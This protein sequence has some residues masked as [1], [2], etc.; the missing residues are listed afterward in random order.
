MRRARCLLRPVSSAKRPVYNVSSYSNRRWASSTGAI[1]TSADRVDMS[2]TL[3]SPYETFLDGRKSERVTLVTETGERAF[4]ANHVPFLGEAHPGVVEVLTREEGNDVTKR[5]FVSAGI[6]TFLPENH[7]KISC[8]EV[9]N[10]SEVDPEAV[11][12]GLSHWNSR[13]SDAK[14]ADEQFIA[15]A[16]VNLHTALADALK[17]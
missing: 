1:E 16:G 6:V 4:L 5:Y 15:Q 17:K 9:V 12:S 14:D 11:A 3:A 10:L 7:C 13:L 2:V 8:G